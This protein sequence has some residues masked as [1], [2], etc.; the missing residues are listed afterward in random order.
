[1][2]MHRRELLQWMLAT[3]GLAAINRLSVSDLESIGVESHKR[4]QA[5]LRSLSAH[6]ARTV[7]AASERIIPRTDTPGA[8][9]ARTTA[10]IDTMLTDWY[11]T[12]DRDRFLTGIA[13]LD[14]RS[15][16]T[17]KRVFVECTVAEQ[18]AL[19]T[20]IDNEVNTLR[21]TNATAANAHWFG[22][23]KYLTAWGYCTS[24]AGMRQ[25]L[26]TWPP[27]MRYD[28]CAPVAIQRRSPS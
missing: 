4:A 18:D 5:Q 25:T 1:M 28:G 3:G 16:A 15:A 21:R 19:L 6:A 27:P 14:M 10:F 23:L 26:R 20:T 17:G 12:T 13:E 24:E 2:T 11:S 9:D 22:M 7:T 8:T